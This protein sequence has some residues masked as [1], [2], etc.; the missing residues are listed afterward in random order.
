MKTTKKY[1]ALFIVLAC[2][3]TGGLL[4]MFDYGTTTAKCLAIAGAAVSFAAG[5]VLGYVFN[6]HNLLPE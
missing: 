6:R 5:I 4:L 2:I 3:G 1:M